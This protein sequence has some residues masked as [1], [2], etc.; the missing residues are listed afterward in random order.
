MMHVRPELLA[1]VASLAAGCDVIFID[2]KAAFDVTGTYT[3]SVTRRDN[4]CSYPSWTPGDSLSARLD[5]RQEL[6]TLTA[7]VTGG[8][9]ELFY[10]AELGSPVLTGELVGGSL[11]LDGIG[12][13]QHALPGCP[14]TTDSRI[15]VL[16]QS[17]GDQLV[18]TVEFR[19]RAAPGCTRECRSYLDVAGV[20]AP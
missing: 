5:V 14:H 2:E 8:R 10:L 6:D 17:A 3:L 13:T 9:V 4:G 15:E 19:A 16:V 11:V 7:T 18:G 1:L 20:R 12:T